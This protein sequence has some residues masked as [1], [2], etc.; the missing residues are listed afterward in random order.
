MVVRHEFD[1]GWAEVASR[2]PHPALRG[3]VRTYYGWVERT[4]EPLRRRELP[5]PDVVAILT[6]GSERWHVELTGSPQGPARF[7]SFVGGLHDA[8]IV[9]AHD[10][11]SH[12]IQVNFTP[13]GARALLG[14]PTHTLTHR[15]VDLED[16]LGA[17]G[18]ALLERLYET[19]SWE[20]R[21]SLLDSVFAAQLAEAPPPSPT[22]V[23]AWRRLAE[24]EGRVAVADLARELGCSRKYLTAVFREQVGLPPKAVAGLLRFHRAIRLL[25]QDD[26]TRFGEIALDCGYYDQSH[27]NRDFRQ[28]TSSSPTEFF[29]RRLP[30][31]LGVAAE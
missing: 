10:G 29:A 22:V 19:S 12:G 16:V 7:G 24:T 5:V 1:G 8:S 13:L 17:R 23:W 26:G 2:E 11:A 9:T 28:Y 15:V 27:F 21:F 25:E 4:L 31:G 30:H 14:V 6:L 18:R 20:G 3:H